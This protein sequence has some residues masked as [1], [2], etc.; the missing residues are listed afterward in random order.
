[1]LWQQQL[2]KQLINFETERQEVCK[3]EQKPIKNFNKFSDDEEEEY[4][5][6]VE[7]RK[8]IRREQKETAKAKKLKIKQKEDKA[9]EGEMWNRLNELNSQFKTLKQSKKETKKVSATI[10]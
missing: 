7:K 6:Q 1:M 10:L 5:Q 8:M 4:K 9:K 3:F 2:A